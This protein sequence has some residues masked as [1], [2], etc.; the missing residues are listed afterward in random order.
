VV[1]ARRQYRA[2]HPGILQRERDGRL[3]CAR[4]F[5]SDW[6][7]SGFIVS[8][9]LPV[10]LRS[11]PWTWTAT[12]SKGGPYV[13]R[14]LVADG[15]RREVLEEV[16]VEGM[17]AAVV[18]LGDRMEASILAT[19]HLKALNVGEIFVKAISDDHAKVL[20]ILGATRVVYPERD[21]AQNLAMSI[22][23]PTVLDYLRLQE[24]IG[25]LELVAPEEFVGRTSCS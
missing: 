11:R 25:I 21:T 4:Y 3:I 24:G 16:G 19:L 8:A 13:D 14:A 7:I 18:S 15:T 23:Q 2:V 9:R 5:S 1:I 6:G 20:T 12:R 22:V 10:E 17:D